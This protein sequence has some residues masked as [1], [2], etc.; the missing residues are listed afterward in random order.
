MANIIQ[1]IL[2]PKYQVTIL[3]VIK[4]NAENIEY[5]KMQDIKFLK[6]FTPTIELVTKKDYAIN[7]CAYHFAKYAPNGKVLNVKYGDGDAI[8]KRIFNKMLK[9]YIAYHKRKTASTNNKNRQR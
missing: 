9:E 7:K 2:L 4:N 6:V 3:D 8:S 1:K 5:M